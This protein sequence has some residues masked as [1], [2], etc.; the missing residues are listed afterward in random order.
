M[1]PFGV[2][3]ARISSLASGMSLTIGGVGERGIRVSSV[4]GGV[5]LKVQDGVNADLSLGSVA[6]R[7][8]SEARDIRISRENESN[9]RV[10]LGAGGREISIDSIVGLVRI[11]RP[12]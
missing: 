7:V 6:G 5:D 8:D 12:A 10:V 2:H 11:R 4:T 3:D 1:A 9:Y